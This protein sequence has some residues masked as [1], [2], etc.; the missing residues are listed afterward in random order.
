MT[1]RC[2]NAADASAASA[3]TVA[4]DLE[5][6]L[7]SDAVSQFPR[8]SLHAFLDGLKALGVELV[9]LTG[10]ST[11]RVRAILHTLAAEGTVPSCAVN[12]PCVE[13]T[14][15]Y[16]D[17]R[18][19]VP[20]TA[21]ERVLLVDDMPG[22][23]PPEQ[24]AHW[25]RIAPFEPP[26]EKD[27]GELSRVLA[28]LPERCSGTALSEEQRGEQHADGRAGYPRAAGLAAGD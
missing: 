9:L 28:I 15:G 3:W 14:G 22:V 24:Q 21:L 17:L 27:D 13:W 2:R 23:L 7:I 8:P 11:G 5:G 4:L 6:T 18:D 19:L 10:V 20:H 25:L 12:L 1:D 16:K 26:F